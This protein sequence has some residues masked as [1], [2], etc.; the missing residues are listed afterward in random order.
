MN[1]SVTIATKQVT[2]RPHERVK[3]LRSLSVPEQ[4]AVVE[5]LSPYVQQQVL[6]ALTDREIVDILDNLD[7]RTAHHVVSRIK[8]TKRREKIV[9][10]L[11]ADI[12]DKVEFFLRF[13]PKAAFSLIHFNYV[14]VSVDHTF[15]ETSSIIEQHYE[16][17]GKFPEI[18]VHNAGVLLGEIPLNILVREQAT[19][20]LERFVVPVPTIVY[21]AEVSE[22]WETLTR[23]EK[24]KVIVLDNDAS[25]LGVIYADDALELVGGL[26][27]ASLYSFAG[28]DSSERPFDSAIKKFHSRSPWLILNLATAFMAAG[29]ILLFQDTVD[30]LTV[31]A[32]YIPIVAGMGG[33]AASQTFAVTVRGITLGSITLRNSWLAIKREVIAAVYNGILIGGV[34]GII[35]LLA[36]QSPWLG[37]VVALSMIG[38]HIVAG[39]AGCIIP[40]LLKR[41]GFDPAMMSMVFISTATDVFGLLFLLGLGAII[42]L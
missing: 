36:S 2:Y 12:K 9:G 26:P 21:Q 22:I 5:S 10:A 30:K 19:L 13:H 15:G 32:V 40:L 33:N 23:A 7:L 8:D 16:E 34:V 39:F 42:L 25:V 27:V 6:Q 18:L 14:L 41:F 31:L 37:V 3:L 35:S 20:P 11:K 4:S 17:T 38:V 29:V 1:S 28:V 24:K